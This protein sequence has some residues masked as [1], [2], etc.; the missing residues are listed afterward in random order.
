M[1]RRSYREWT[2]DEE[3]LL[4]MMREHDK[5]STAE[6]AK[7]LNRTCVSVESRLQVLRGRGLIR[8]RLRA[9][10]PKALTNEV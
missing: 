4:C 7:R 10:S 3:W 6:C 5:L 8:D 1:P 9:K 2:A